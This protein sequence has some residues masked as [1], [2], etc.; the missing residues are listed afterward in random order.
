MTT[1]GERRKPPAERFGMNN[2][3]HSIP[4]YL[5]TVYLPLQSWTF[6][7]AYECKTSRCVYHSIETDT[8]IMQTGSARGQ[9]T[10][11]LNAGSVHFITQTGSHYKLLRSLIHHGCACVWLCI[12]LRYLCIRYDIR[13]RSQ[14]A[15]GATIYACETSFGNWSIMCVWNGSAILNYC[16]LWTDNRG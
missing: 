9:S 2:S 10:V 12:S 14:N 13:R 7:Y 5:S 4:A 6:I 1:T 3:C 16:L 11:R 8:R 15:N